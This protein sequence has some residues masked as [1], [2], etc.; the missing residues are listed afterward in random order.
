MGMRRVSG[1]WAVR[2]RVAGSRSLRIVLVILLAGTLA[3][4][5]GGDDEGSAPVA[6]THAVDLPTLTAALPDDARGVFAADLAALRAGGSAD[7]V[8]AL[9]GGEGGDPVLV[10]E[11]LA[12]IGALAGAFGV[13]DDVTSALFAQTTDNAEGSLLLA[14][15]DAAAL[16]DAVASWSEPAS[17][18]GPESRPLYPDGDGHRAVTLPGGVLAVGTRAA[19]EAVVDAADGTTTAADSPIAPFLS[20]LDADADLSLV[21]GLPALLEEVAPA[22]SLRSAA[23]MS[24]ALD[25][26]DGDLEGSL[27]FHTTNADAFV[28]RYNTL[29]RYAVQGDDPSEEP[30]TVAAPVAEGLDR[31]VVPLP[32]SPLDGSPEATLAVRNV[33]KKLFVGMEANDYAEGVSSTG[34]APWIDLIIKSEADGDTP[35]A[36]GAVFFR[37]RFRD[38]AAREAFARDVLPPGFTL[39]PTQFLES[40]DP[41][42]EYFVALML[43]IA[44]GGSIVDGARA[45]WDVFVSP[46]AGADPDSPARPRYMIIQALS[47]N[48]SFDP[49]TLLSEA[50]PVSYEID[51]DEVVANVSERVEGEDVPVFTSSFPLPDPDTAEPVRWTAEMAIANDYMHWPNGVYDHIVYNATTYNWEGRYVDTERTTIDDRSRWAQYIEPELLDATYY[52]NTLEYVA[53]PLANLDSPYLDVTPAQRADLLAFKDNG[54]QRGV[55]RGRVEQLFQ[56]TGDAYVG[57]EVPNEV[58]TTYYDFDVTDPDGLEEALDLPDGVSLMPTTRFEGEPEGYRLTLGVRQVEDAPEG[59]TAQWSVVVDDG[60]GRPRQQVVDLMTEDFAADPV[61]IVA[62]PSDVRHRLADGVIRTRLSSPTVSFDAT[63]PT[64]GSTEEAVTMDWVESG[65]EVC[66]TGGACDRYFYDAETL[67]VPVHRATDVTVDEV[68]TPWDEFVDATPTVFY[69]DNAQGYAVKR[70]HDL[71]VVVD[72]P[73]LGG[74]E[75]AT[76]AIEGQGTLV[77]RDSQVADSEYTYTGDAVVEGDQLTFSIDQQVDN[78]LGVTHIYTEGSFDL[79][80]GQG[81]QTVVDCRGAALMCSDIEPG[82]EAPYTAQGL[83]ASDPDAITWRVDIAVDLEN[84]G[85]AD[86]ASTFR[87]T[88]NG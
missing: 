88:R 29:N 10:D 15:V 64:A 59:T 39:A 7:E 81:T 63:V 80:T 48:V 54:H 31:V 83:D 55:M 50:N 12:G 43:Y 40:D 52:L 36:P 57:F 84:F 32:A 53:S 47:A 2:A 87:A 75:G 49:T 20:A 85:R 34:N 9:L 30:L 11:P 27:A 44:G 17:T 6:T 23:V 71:E 79:T 66:V 69:R 62:L 37:W 68:T 19:V 38:R 77:G 28:D 24:G 60:S 56:G 21:Y 25:V 22:E 61:G 18:Y 73:E 4:C 1:T 51:G 41:E 33:A 65:D 3:T 13:T 8:E 5:A 26:V 76:H 82:S 14:K 45:E 35:P 74:L 78:A 46:P 72:V 58:P 70:W 42:G 16:D 67:D 86:S